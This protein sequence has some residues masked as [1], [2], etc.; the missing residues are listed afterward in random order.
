LGVDQDDISVLSHNNHGIGGGF[1][2][3]FEA[4]NLYGGVWVF[5]KPKTGFGFRIVFDNCFFGFFSLQGQGF[6]RYDV[7][8]G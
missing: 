3:P 2:D 4:V 7:K 5:G 6:P 1:Q 8:T